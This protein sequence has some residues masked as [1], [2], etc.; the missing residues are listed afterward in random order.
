MNSDI[1]EDINS[2]LPKVEPSFLSQNW[3]WIVPLAM[4][5][6]LLLGA[7]LAKLKKSKKLSPYEISKLRL[8]TA[9][10]ENDDKI[11]AE[12]VSGALREYISE[13]FAIPAPERTTEEFLTLASSNSDIA[14]SDRKT[15]EQILNIS[16][17]AKFAGAQFSAEN[18][19]LM[20]KL[21]EE[22]IESDNQ[23]RI[24]KK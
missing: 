2:I 3:T 13:I 9:R 8:A 15:I 22:F 12:L 7:L 4:L 16:D 21:A 14:E 19:D 11:Y 5:L 24:S 10:L 6:T 18:R 23:K 17:M 1:F 20:M